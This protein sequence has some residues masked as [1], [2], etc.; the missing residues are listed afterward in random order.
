MNYQNK[1]LPL[2]P[3]EIQTIPHSN[4]HLLEVLQIFSTN[5]LRNKPTDLKVKN[6]QIMQ[7]VI[8]YVVGKGI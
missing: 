1:L 3:E 6:E 5:K 4:E 2:T 7:V 8:K